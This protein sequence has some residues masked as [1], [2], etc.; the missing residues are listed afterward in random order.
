MEIGEARCIVTLK[1][2]LGPVHTPRQIPDVD[3]CVGVCAVD[4]PA[5]RQQLANRSAKVYCSRRG[6]RYH[7]HKYLDS[8]GKYN[9][10]EQE[11]RLVQRHQ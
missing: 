10:G 8:V 7:I 2:R 4:V 3:G 5:D 9:P 1:Q 11:K 6:R